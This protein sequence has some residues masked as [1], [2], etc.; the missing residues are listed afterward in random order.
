MNNNK[1]VVKYIEDIVVYNGHPE[2]IGFIMHGFK[3]SMREIVLP[4]IPLGGLIRF[5][6]D[7]YNMPNK[8]YFF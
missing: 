3:Y 7:Y 2:L 6:W 8:T 5:I 1:R 4:M